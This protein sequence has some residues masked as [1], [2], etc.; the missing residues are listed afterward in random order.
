[1]S[2]TSPQPPRSPSTPPSPLASP[3]HSIL[4]RT[5]SSLSAPS[6]PHKK[7]LRFT[8]VH[9][10]SDTLLS[11]VG[12]NEDV[13]Y[14]GRTV[15]EGLYTDRITT[16]QRRFLQSDPGTPN[17][18]E[19]ADQIRRTLSLASVDSLLLL[20]ASQSERTKFLAE[21]SRA[22]RGLVWRDEG[23]L[24]LLPQDNERAVVLALKRGLRS[25]ILAFSV[26]SGINVLLLL[27]RLLR[28]HA[29]KLSLPLL[30]RTIFGPEPFRFGGMIGTFT[31][32]YTFTLHLLRLAP[33]LSYF[34]RRIRAG[35]WNKTTFGPPEREGNEGERRWQAAAAGAVGSLGLLWE[36][37]S[38]R[39][40]VAQQMFVRGLQASYNQYTPRFGIHIAHGDLLLFGACCGQI[41]F[42]FLMSP[43]TIPKEYNN[44]IL[45]ASRVPSFAI[46]ANRTQ[47][48]QG[49]IQDALVQEALNYKGITATNRIRL[50][51]VLRKIRDGQQ[52]VAVPCGMVHPWCNTCTETN[53]RR[54]FAVCR[55]MLPVYSALHLIPML[56]LRRHHVKRDPIRMMARALWGISRSCSFLGVFVVIY[57]VLFCARV[58]ALEKSRGP[59]FM[60]SLLKRKEVFW[61]LGF[62]TCLSLLVE[63]KKRRAELAMY[64][65]PRA[66]ESA[67]SGARKRAWVPLVPFGET[68]LGAAA[69]AMVMDAYKHEP[70]AMS[71]IVRRLLFQLVGPA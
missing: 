62:T 36:S 17:F 31:L 5:A 71:G 64:V 40:G 33:P 4:R 49:Y 15:E 18:Q 20:S 48:R 70:D 3:T 66:L 45:S 59:D 56:V 39:T 37:K 68:I 24:C 26:R 13:Y 60:R 2:P 52:P 46:R 28:K 54:F 30:R 63:E 25:F 51:D 53:F 19:T 41:M 8:Q 34:R 67:W 10:D 43:E 42:A 12:Q 44:W 57:Q 61:A 7:M 65:L 23:E 50:E 21:V 47:V 16:D 9:R 14:H 1:M 29:P 27:F 58:Q 22:G 38:R 69:M 35:L 32:L 11:S 55:F 6:H